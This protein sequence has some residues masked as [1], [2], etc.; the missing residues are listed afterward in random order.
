[1]WNSISLWCW[2]TFS[3]WLMMLSIFSCTYWPSVCLLWK[4]V[5]SNS[6]PIL[7]WITLF[8]LFRCRSS[9]YI[10]DISPYLQIFSPSVWVVFSSSWYSNFMHKSF[11][12]WWSQY[13]FSI[14][15]FNIYIYFSFVTFALDVQSKKPLPNSVL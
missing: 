2:F 1:M 12:F 14:Y 8:L 11:L 7:S 10:L 9:L 6:L 4:N 15:I 13:I 3:Q 5:S